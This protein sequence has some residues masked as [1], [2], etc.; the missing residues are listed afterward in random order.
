MNPPQNIATEPKPECPPE[1]LAHISIDSL[2]RISD[3]IR[4][5]VTL[6]K[7]NEGQKA[8]IQ[9]LEHTLNH[10]KSAITR[11][12]DE[13]ITLRAAAEM[14]GSVQAQVRTTL[15]QKD[16]QITQLQDELKA[17]HCQI[18]SMGRALQAKPNIQTPYW[19]IT[20][21]RKDQEVK[22]LTICEAPTESIIAHLTTLFN[23]THAQYTYVNH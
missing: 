23:A 5:W 18:D 15:R 3:I 10:R 19:H 1:A 14:V 20:F 12:T 2:H 17:A 16:A 8:L 21:Y 9:E 6:K 4:E 13:I 11:L 7:M 22:R